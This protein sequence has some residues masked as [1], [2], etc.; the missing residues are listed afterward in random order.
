M[1][2]PHKN[3]PLA[4]ES[5]DQKIDLLISNLWQRGTESIHAMHVV[6]TDAISHQNKYMYKCLQTEE[7]DNKKKYLKSFLQQHCHLSSSI[8]LVDG[9]IGVEAEST[10]KLIAIHLATKWKHPYSRICG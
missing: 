8:I 5:S 7:Q 9:L 2:S 3:S 10:L 1:G 6:N 4:T